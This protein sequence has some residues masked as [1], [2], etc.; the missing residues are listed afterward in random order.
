MTSVKILIGQVTDS[1]YSEPLRPIEVSEKLTTLTG[2][3]TQCL[4]EEMA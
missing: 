2:R 4:P 3:R 1:I